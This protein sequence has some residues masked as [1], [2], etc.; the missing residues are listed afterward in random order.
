MSKN[1]YVG[2]SL[3]RRDG[4]AKVTGQ[5]AFTSDMSA[6]G[7]LHAK[8]LRSPH[9]HARIRSIDTSEAEKL[10]GVKAILHHGN[11]RNNP[12]N[13]AAPMYLTVPYLKPILDQTIF[14]NR[15]RHV[16]DEIAAVAATT[17]DIARQAVDLIKIEYEILPSVIDA[18]EAL[19]EAAPEIHNPEMTPEGKNVVADIIRIPPEMPDAT[20]DKAFARADVVVEREYK[21]NVVKQA[22]METHAALAQVTAEGQVVIHS[23]TQTPHPTKAIIAKTFDIPASRIRVLNPPYV[24]GGFGVRIGLS[25]KAEVAAVALA[26]VTGRPVKVNYS[27]YEDF[28][29]SD[30]RH[31]AY[32]KVKLGATRD[33][34]FVALDMKGLTNTG[35][36]CTFGAELPAVLGAMNLAI[37]NVPTLRYVGHSVYT[38]ATPAGAMRGFGN[39]QG[40]MAL[41]RVVEIMAKELGMDARELREK[42]IMKAGDPWFLP[43]P[44]SSSEL[45]ECIRQCADSI[46][47]ERRGSLKPEGKKLRGI[48]MA[49]GTHVSNAWPFCVDYDNAYVT[50]QS[51]GSVNLAAGIPDI[52]TGTSTSLPQV[53][54]EALGV[55]YDHITFTFG[56]T[57][58]TPFDIGSHAS[59]TLYASGL[60]VKA[61]AED[62]QRQI[63]EYAARLFKSTPERLIMEKSVIKPE[64]AAGK[65]VAC[66]DPATLPGAQEEAL[67]APVPPP[68]SHGLVREID[69][70]GEQDGITLEAL[71]YYAHIRNTQF[72][73]VGKIIPPNTPP[74]HC[75]TAE[76]EIDTET[77]QVS[78]VKVAAAHDVGTAVNPQIVEGQ[79]E[80]AVVQGIGMALSEEILYTAD[81]KPAH[82]S[83]S[84]Y[85][86]PTAEDIPEIDAIIVESHD[87]TGPYGA[88][89]CGECGSVCPTSAIVNAVANALGKDV[90]ETPL[91]AER[92]YHLIHD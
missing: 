7:M 27:R 41:E 18:K 5:G 38:N 40:N 20:M 42:N 68:R 48:G 92:V 43:Y 81:H 64:S 90:R 28:V 73:G 10:P 61:A 19:T 66:V 37:Y 25:G 59:R 3:T 87:P 26:Q 85:M 70:T 76:V 23:T 32:V 44:C 65:L 49:V 62:A 89:G 51:D 6:P 54:A 15:P 34:K 2:K 29:A 11:T 91:T 55:D 16:G 33:G 46:G 77:G 13:T 4:I 24:G 31:A 58:S 21:L 86:V 39:P 69:S 79:I 35:A 22:Q 78:V 12:F 56:D 53:C 72:I 67:A 36:Y 14:T 1:S 30:T 52:G 9:P 80:G 17:T 50:V 83:F 8:F 63:L 74:W 82:K 60:A 45:A 57:E 75:C 47:W 88:K 71:A 84:S